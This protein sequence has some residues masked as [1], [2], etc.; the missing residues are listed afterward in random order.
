MSI[1]LKFLNFKY[2]YNRIERF[3]ENGY[4]SIV[5]NNP[6]SMISEFENISDEI[7]SRD[8]LEKMSPLRLAGSTFTKSKILILTDLN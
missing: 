3:K 2:N 5:F 1:R 6:K 8:Y 7:Y 4:P